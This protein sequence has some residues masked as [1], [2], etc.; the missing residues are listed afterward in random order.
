MWGGKKIYGLTKTIVKLQQ[1]KVHVICEAQEQMLESI[2]IFWNDMDSKMTMIIVQTLN[3]GRDVKSAGDKDAVCEIDCFR[4][5]SQA[6]TF[7]LWTAR[8]G[9]E[10]QQSLLVLIIISY[11]RSMNFT[12]HSEVFYFL[13]IF[14]SKHL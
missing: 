10:S 5:L 13:R 6:R 1:N 8:T 7:F 12:N 11:R 2:F 14:F 4:S 9:A 3:N